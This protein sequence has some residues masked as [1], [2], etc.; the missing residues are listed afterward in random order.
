MPRTHNQEWLLKNALFG[1]CN[2]DCA[3][4]VSYHA[5][6]LRL[7]HEGEPICVNCWNE[8]ESNG[9]SPHWNMLKDFNP[10]GDIA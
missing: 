2:S 4:E 10:F 5:S 7:T 6:D 1:C 9:I 3:C 8:S